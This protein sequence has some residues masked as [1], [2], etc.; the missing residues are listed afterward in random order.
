MRQVIL[1]YNK[2]L[3]IHA[4]RKNKSLDS[5]V[6]RKISYFIKVKHEV[7]NNRTHAPK[8]HTP[9]WILKSHNTIETRTS[10]TQ[11]QPF[12]STQ[13]A[14]FG[15]KQ[16]LSYLFITITFTFWEHIWYISLSMS[17]ITCMWL[18]GSIVCTNSYHHMLNV[19]CNKQ[20]W[21]LLNYGPSLSIM[22][23]C[24]EKTSPPQPL[25]FVFLK[26]VLVLTRKQNLKCLNC[27]RESKIKQAYLSD[28]LECIKLSHI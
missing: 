15:Q 21:A 14:T 13:E 18:E 2:K 11:L 4:F 28:N 1:T 8:F 24:M 12:S 7:H 25:T 6:P 22:S 5:I 19:V 16:N 9:I 17:S 20:P 10:I 23:N 26:N 27:G 3:I